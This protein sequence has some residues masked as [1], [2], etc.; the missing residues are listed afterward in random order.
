MENKQD[1]V[2]TKKGTLTKYNGPGGDVTIPEEIGRAH[3]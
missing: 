3:V 2:I 1:F